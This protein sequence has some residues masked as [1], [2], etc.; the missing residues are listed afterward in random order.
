MR[1]PILTT[2]KAKRDRK[3]DGDWEDTT[4]DEKRTTAPTGAIPKMT[5]KK[6]TPM[7]SFLVSHTLD[8]QMETL[9]LMPAKDRKQRGT[10]SRSDITYIS[11]SPELN[12]R[13]V[14]QQGMIKIKDGAR[15]TPPQPG[16]VP[17]FAMYFEREKTADKL[18]IS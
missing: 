5:K 14:K 1:K 11:A 15:K 17:S 7:N 6:Q 12:V 13:Q 2:P 3:E 10:A 18:I 8:M 9:K 4:G 16:K